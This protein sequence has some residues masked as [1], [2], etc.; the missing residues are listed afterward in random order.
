M[1][2]IQSPSSRSV[3]DETASGRLHKR[4]LAVMVALVVYGSLFP[5]DYQAHQASWADVWQLLRPGNVR[6]SRSDLIGNILLFVPLGLLLVSPL[7]RSRV[8]LALLAGVLLALGV[9]YLQF[10]FPQ[11][12]PSGV[13]ALLNVVGMLLGWGLGHLAVPWLQRSVATKLPRPHF[14]LLASALMLLWLA[15]RWFPVV[16]TLDIQNVRNGLKPLLDWSDVDRLDVLRHLV[17]WLVFLRLARYSLLQRLGTVSWAALCVLIVVVEPLFL[18]NAVGPD[19]LVGLIIALLLAPLLRSGPVSLAL[20]TCAL[21]GL[22]VASALEPFRFAW[23]GGFQWVP[24]AGSLTGDP[25]TALPVLLEKLY[26]YGSLV[27]FARYLGLSHASTAIWVGLLLLTVELV[28]LWLPERTP[29]ITDPLLALLLTGLMKPVFD[30]ARA[31]AV[32]ARPT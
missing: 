12:D 9:Q 14:A 2:V 17:G 1:S 20:V 3:S 19:N 31:G 13:D 22:I 27:F 8:C 11:R 10:W 25:L 28:Q 15:D 30:R 24:F 6:Y 4:L 23:V 26:W 5:F 16:P 32:G 21:V 29:E 18:N 7:L